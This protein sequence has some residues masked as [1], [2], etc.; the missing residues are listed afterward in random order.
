MDRYWRR[1]TRK[2]ELGKKL[3][4]DSA[5]TIRLK[6]ALKT[7]KRIVG[8]SLENVFAVVRDKNG[9]NST[10]TRGFVATIKLA[11]FERGR[12]LRTDSFGNEASKTPIKSIAHCS[13][14]VFSC[15]NADFA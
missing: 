12:K 3:Q 1:K 10:S 7:Q 13:W 2:V 4:C 8:L 11:S 9:E 15:S 14:C 5:V 6:N